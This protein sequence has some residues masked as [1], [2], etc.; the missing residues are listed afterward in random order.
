MHDDNIPLRAYKMKMLNTLPFRRS[1]T[2]QG[3]G[4]GRDTEKM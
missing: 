4:E 1:K 3:V 2:K